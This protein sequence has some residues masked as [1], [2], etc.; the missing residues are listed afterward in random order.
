MGKITPE[1]RPIT[2]MAGKNERK[3]GKV[4]IE[5][6]PAIMMELAVRRILAS[7]RFDKHSDIEKMKI[8]ADVNPVKRSP[9]ETRSRPN[10]QVTT[11]IVLMEGLKA[12][13]IHSNQKDGYR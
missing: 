6:P 1:Q 13:N 11:E 3:W 2:I 9:I 10:S 4:P 7:P 12:L 8:V 5:R